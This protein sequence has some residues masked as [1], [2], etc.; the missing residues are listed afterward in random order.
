LEGKVT[1]YDK[2]IKQYERKEESLSKRIK[3]DTKELNRLNDEVR[4][5]RY[6]SLCSKFNCSEKDLE[7]VLEKE[8]EQIQKMKNSGLSDE[9]I[10]VICKEKEFKNENKIF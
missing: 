2:K 6:L 10:D 5:M 8:H 9:D 4:L 3:E 7:S 1:L